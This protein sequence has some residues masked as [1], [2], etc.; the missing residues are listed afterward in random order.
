[1]VFLIPEVQNSLLLTEA[2]SKF[3]HD[4]IRLQE[5]DLKMSGELWFRS[6][7]K[8]FLFDCVGESPPQL[9]RNGDGQIQPASRLLYSIQTA[10]KSSRLGPLSFIY[11]CWKNEGALL[12]SPNKGPLTTLCPQNT[13]HCPV[14]TTVLA[15]QLRS[16]LE[17]GLWGKW[18]WLVWNVARTAQQWGWKGFDRPLTGKEA[19][20]FI[21][22]QL[23]GGISP[24][25]A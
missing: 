10:S 8:L 19:L 1:M 23:M 5:A 13:S 3:C 4:C 18:F 21:S 7:T 14:W 25:A 22:G 20:D 11:I 12:P 24:T 16:L 6:K 15:S 17:C 9:H 2:A